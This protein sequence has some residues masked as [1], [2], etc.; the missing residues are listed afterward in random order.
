MDIR[1]RQGLR[2][3]AKESL[4]AASYHPGKLALLHTGAAAALSLLMT[5]L[6]F[7]LSKQIAGTGGLAGM[8]LQSILSTA[9]AM[10]SIISL[11]VIPFWELGFVYATARMARKAP[12]QPKDLLRGFLRFG[13]ALRLALLQ[14]VLYVGIA[15]LSVQL[16]SGIYL[17]TPFSMQ[18]MQAMEQL[19]LQEMTSQEMM[20]AVAQMDPGLMIPMYVISALV[21]AALAIPVHYRFRLAQYLIVD[22]P[23]IG[24]LVALG[25]SHRLMR[26]N[27]WAMFRLDLS[28]WWFYG[29][30][31]LSVLVGYGDVLCAALGIPLPISET[32][33]LFG[34]FIIHC[35]VQLVMAWYFASPVGVTYAT[36]YDVLR[37]MALD[38]EPS[39]VKNFPWDYLP[40]QEKPEQ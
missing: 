12:T 25:M 13:P 19:P 1:D 28:F 22:D 7:I 37:E 40:E 33:G 23:K 14:G 27:R 10:L 21:L 34:F 26:H 39:L 9:Q 4:A 36:A 18:L 32:A 15:L 24:A 11:V 29:L 6:N 35:G 3:R 17:L 16:S 20:L 30:K 38:A 31:L 2:L 5:L 8:G